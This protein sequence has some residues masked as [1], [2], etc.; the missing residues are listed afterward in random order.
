MEKSTNKKLREEL[1]R[2]QNIVFEEYKDN[3]ISPKKA[4]DI[5][6]QIEKLKNMI[7]KMTY[8]HL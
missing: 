8:K 3:K 4:V 6:R 1:N 7:D 5:E 2:I